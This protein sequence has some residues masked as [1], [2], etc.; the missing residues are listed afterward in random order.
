MKKYSLALLLLTAFANSAFSQA[1]MYRTYQDYLND[2]VSK[3]YAEYVGAFHALG[4]FTV[5]FKT[6]D[7]R[8]VKI[9]I[10]KGKYWGYKT[11]KGLI[12]KINFF[13]F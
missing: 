9:K 5:T 10:K 3:E 6:E 1:G 11:E 2:E 12:Y 7:D 13:I 4:H 8:E